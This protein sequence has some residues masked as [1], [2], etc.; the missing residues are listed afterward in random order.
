M[1]TLSGYEDLIRIHDGENS[2]VY[3]AWQVKDGRSVILKLLKADYPTPDQLRRYRQEYHLTHQLQLPEVI[4]AYGLDP[5]QRTLVMILEDFNGLDLKQWLQQ[6]PQGLTVEA[7]LPLAIKIASALGQL[8]SQAVIHKDINPANIVFNPK[9]RTL[10]LI[11]LGI[12]TQ[13]S[14]ENPSLQAPGAL[15]GTLSYL[16]PEQTGRMNRVLDYRTDFYS[17]GVTFY[18]LLTGTLPF[19]SD[20]PMEL[21]HCHLAKQPASLLDVKGGQVP[22]IL[23]ELVNTLMAKNAEERYQSAWGLK[24]DLETCWVQWQE[25]RTIARFPLG[26]HDVSDRFHIPQKLY[27]RER[28]LAALLTAF[29]R[30]AGVSPVLGKDATAEL[31]LVTGYSGIGKSALVRSLYKPMT[32]RRGYFISG[33]FDQFQRN[34]PYSA[35]VNAFAGLVMQLLA[36]PEAILQQWRE[37][38]L[39][40]LGPNGQVVIEVIPD[41]ALIIG[42]QPPVPELGASESQNRFNRVFQRFVQ[43]CCSPEHPLVIFLDDMQWADRATLNLIER[44][45]EDRQSQHLLLIIAYRDNEVLIGHPLSLTIAQ[46][47]RQG[48]PI[49]SITLTPLPLEQI[50]QLIADTL[51][52]SPETVRDLA[53]LVLR[54]TEGNP[55]FANQFLKTLYSEHLLT[56]NYH[57][58]QWQWDLAQIEAIGFTDNVVELM[59]EQLQKLPPSVQVALSTAAY[60]GAEFDLETLAWVKHQTPASLFADLKLAMAQGF[61]MAR[62][63]LDEQLLI[64]DYQFGHDR[65]QQAAYA[66]IPAKDQAD[67]HLQIGRSLL[68]RLADTDLDDRLFDLVEHLNHGLVG[69][70]DAEERERFAGLNLRAGQKAIGA[71]AYKAAMTYLDRGISLLSSNSWDSHYELSLSLHNEAVKAAFLS[72]EFEHMENW[73]TIVM[74]KAKTALDRVQVSAIRI[75]A[76]GSQNRLLEAISSGLD[77]LAQLGIQFP[78]A[79]E[80][81]DFIQALAQIETLITD[82]QPSELI[83]LPAMQDPTA[84]A[85][86]QLLVKLGPASFVS[87]LKLSPLITL[88]Q[89]ELSILYGNAPLSAVAYS[90]Y[91][92]ILCGLVGDLDKGY[93]FGQVAIGLISQSDSREFEATVLMMVHSFI[94]HWKIHLRETLAHLQQAHAVGI[95]A[96]DFAYAGYA[97]FDYCTHAYLIGQSLSEVQSAMQHY[98]EVLK[99]M[100]QKSA[101]SYLQGYQQ[102]IENLTRTLAHPYTFA[103]EILDEQVVIPLLQAQHNQAGLWHFYTVKLPLCYWFGQFALAYEVSQWA[104][105][106]ISS[107]TAGVAVPILYFYDALTCLALLSEHPLDHSDPL[108]LQVDKNQHLL[109]QWSVSA[110]MNYRHKFDL[111]AAEKCRVL[112]QTIAAIDLYDRAIAGA[113]A[114]AYLQEEALANELA[115][116]FYLNWGKE[117]IA[118]VYL[119]EAHY[120][121]LC[122]GATAK[123]RHLETQYPQCFTREWSSQLAP[124]RTSSQTSDSQSSAA[125]DLSTVMKSSQAIASEIVLENLLQTL[126]KILLENAGAQ[127]GCLVLPT[128]RAGGVEHFSVAIHSIADIANISPPQP[129]HQILPESV[130]HYVARTHESVM[131]DEASR[132]GQFV[133][134]PYIQLAQPLSIL[135]YPLLDQ[136]QLVGLVYLENKVTA[137]AFTRDRIELLQILSGQAA[138]ALSNAQ[139]YA[140][141]RESEQQ[142]KQFLEAVPVGIGVLDA[143]GHPYYMNQRAKE[144]LGQGIAAEA[145]AEDI[146]LVYQTYIVQTDDLYPNEKLPIIRALKGEASSVE[147]IEIHQGDRVIPIESWGTPI[148]NKAGDVQYA[149]TAFQD[150]T[151]RK[152]A[153][154]IFADYSRE[155][156]REVSQR[157]AELAQI[158]QQLQQEIRERQQA[159]QNLQ[160]ANR[161]LLRLAT[162]DGLTQVANRRYFD[163]QLQQEWQR[164]GREQQFLSLILFDVDYFKRYN[165]YY[166]HQAGDACLVQVAQAAQA[167][168]NRPADLIA[169]YGGEEFVMILPHTDQPGAIAIA[170][171]IQQAIRARAIPHAKSEVSSIVSVS[172]GIASLMPTPHQSPDVLIA[173]ADQA[174]YAAKQQGRDRYSISG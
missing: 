39:D 158:N 118:Q 24:A 2:Q 115:G 125:L 119:Q 136:N 88:K 11:D 53:E 174:L 153:E 23:A 77:I 143:K 85:A 91:G 122:W 47:Q 137:G 164:L 166:G 104:Q 7:F 44:L 97:A 148:Y 62:S 154:Q 18:E 38:L 109:E 78:E 10:K 124:P 51:H 46:I 56:F 92:L 117:K 87:S 68:N 71:S 102:A 4:K 45:L 76:Y 157:T 171:R 127:T 82:T 129:I 19:T 50:G 30:V 34:I 151:E 161:E 150:I 49:E 72:A 126:M 67:R 36:E 133:Q 13:L 128:S 131:L 156:E 83:N 12:S 152:R 28:E 116:R 26:Q 22:P 108:W 163:Q 167:G 106:S 101:L 110:P 69:V 145:T 70:V 105:Q 139:L 90:S 65:I 99:Q 58:R 64:Q 15:E 114:Q 59:V 170:E 94:S 86:L 146:A 141:V 3:R 29:E 73:A 155:L 134:D 112:G 42:A 121:Y 149:I 40:A 33:K 165:D 1:I 17:L 35:V 66:L 80:P 16:S 162:M 173:L 123:V 5:W 142:L 75:E 100:G 37:Q 111:V 8:H 98:S 14:R 6:Y 81:V 107:G 113:K 169:R 168:V 21:V 32:A 89:V 61:V 54:K 31:V 159:E 52:Q 27:G 74:A 43:A 96:G 144:L 41:M 93:D 55:F 140:R 172:L 20:D 57:L 120:C 9:T 48:T 63:S 147:D 25:T 135:C 103:G 95:A 160:V 132:S 84:L 130:L 79:P 138:I 60:L